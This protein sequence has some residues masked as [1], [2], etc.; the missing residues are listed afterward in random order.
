MNIFILDEDVKRCAEYHCDKHVIKM[1]LESAQML[2]T[3]LREN[4]QEYGYK[5]THKN[6]PCTKWA[7]SS[8]SNWLWLRDLAKELNS[9]YRFRYNKDVNHKSYDMIMTLPEPDIDDIG[10][11]DFALA[12]P[13]EY[14]TASNTVESYR[15]YYIGEKKDIANWT[16]RNVPEWFILA[17]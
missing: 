6:H 3:V 15:K 10:L 7:A 11:T 2:S 12:M 9:E 4:G 5:P 1:I 16:G 17:S 8:K 13:D 14:K